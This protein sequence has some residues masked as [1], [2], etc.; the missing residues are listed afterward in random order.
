MSC[1]RKCRRIVIFVCIDVRLMHITVLDAS[2]R[3]IS[4]V[5]ACFC[6]DDEKCRESSECGFSTDKERY[7]C[8]LPTHV[9]YGCE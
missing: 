1:E 9:E 5:D 2:E 3:A 8:F 7:R 4:V 6:A